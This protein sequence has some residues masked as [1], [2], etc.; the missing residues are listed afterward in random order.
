MGNDVPKREKPVTGFV[1]KSGPLK[2]IL[3]FI[4]AL[5][6]A[7]TAIYAFADGWFWTQ[8]EGDAHVKVLDVHETEFS[9]HVKDF[10]VQKALTGKDIEYLK[11]QG[12][13]IIE[14]Q[15]EIGRAVRARKSRMRDV[16]EEEEVP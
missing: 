16:A 12:R 2:A 14:N 5:A 6:V 10:E 11:E 4:A 7:L 9:S 3:V 8:E 13:E 1:I 15:I